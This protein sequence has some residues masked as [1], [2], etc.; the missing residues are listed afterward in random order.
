MAVAWNTAMF[1]EVFTHPCKC[2]LLLRLDVVLGDSNG[3]LLVRKYADLKIF[4]NSVQ[5]IWQDF[6]SKIWHIISMVS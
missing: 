1:H 4:D 5:H 3:Q 2:K 6:S